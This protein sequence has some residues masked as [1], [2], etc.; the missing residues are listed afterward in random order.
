[1]P[2]PRAVKEQIVKDLTS[3]LKDAETIYLADLTGL[4]VEALTDLR[5]R[6]RAESVEC[7][8]IKN[9]LTRFAVKNACLPDLGEHLDGPTALVLSDA[10]VTPAKILT[11]FGN[12]HEASPRI[13]GGLLTGALIDVTQIEAMSK[14]PSREELLARTVGAI[15]APIH[16]L[17]FSLSG[18]LG[19]MVGVLAAVARKKESEGSEDGGAE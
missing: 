12:T 10:P 18:V 5:S 2:Q 8:V 13:K 11:D 4:N 6:F 9:T 3:R 1:M 16:G 7:Q 19:N 15:A 14:L 17:V